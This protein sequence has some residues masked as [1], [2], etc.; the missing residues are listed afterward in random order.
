MFC[1]LFWSCTFHSL[2][3]VVMSK[4]AYNFPAA[5]DHA[6]GNGVGGFISVGVGPQ[7]IALPKF[8]MQVTWH[9][10]LPSYKLYWL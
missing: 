2:E 7:Y 10:Q 8:Y 1:F 5:N 6:N 4:G 3:I 9:C